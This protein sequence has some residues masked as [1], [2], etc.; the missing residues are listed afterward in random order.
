MEV[1]AND[2]VGHREITEMWFLHET[3]ADGIMESNEVM[4]TCTEQ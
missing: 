4:K 3:N 1:I 2:G